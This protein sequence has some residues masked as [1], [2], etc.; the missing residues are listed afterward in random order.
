MKKTLLFLIF[1]NAWIG[2]CQLIFQDNFSSYPT[3]LELSGQGLWSNNPIAPNVGIGACL[4]ATSGSTC[5]GTK[6]IGQTVAY[7]NYGASTK[8]IEIGPF[9][10]GVAHIIDPA[11]TNGD[12]Y[13]G[14]VLNI[15]TAPDD[16][17]FPVDILRIINSD[18][19]MVT[20]RMILKNT[21]FGYQIGIR[22][23][24]A[25]NDTAYTTDSYNFNE[26]VLVIL[27][28]SH[29]DGIDDDVLS[30]FVN[31]NYS[32]GEPLTPA[33]VTADGF[34]QSGAI[35][36]VAFRLNYNVAAAM[37]TGF[38]GLVSTSTTWEGLTFQP[39]GV[40]YF[41]K[42][43]FSI[44]TLLDKGALQ[45]FSDNEMNAVQMNIF[46]ITG[47]LVEQHTLDISSGNSEI[48]LSSKLHSGMYIA[49]FIGKNGIRHNYKFI[50]Q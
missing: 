1:M 14:L 39:L 46:T 49:Q 37:P 40:D 29:L 34:D 45:L 50:T 13:I 30:V 8:S 26:N 9:K 38:A 27:K 32:A 25:G 22:K 44:S 35:D 33:A 24:A 23:G 3:G 4:P 7:L 16:A 21:G 41:E 48:P 2:Q 20:F 42:N 10:D 19:T 17:G 43:Q 5:S 31:P 11:I 36:R 6:I 47:S 15:T 12:L 28:Y 18:P